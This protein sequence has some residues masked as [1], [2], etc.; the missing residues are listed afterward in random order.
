[1]SKQ[2]NK[3][4]SGKGRKGFRLPLDDKSGK[5]N[6]KD[7]AILMV[8]DTVLGVLGGMAGSAADKFSLVA[9]A[10]VSLAGHYLDSRA[11]QSFG[12]GMIVSNG[13]TRNASGEK[14]YENQS[15]QGFSPVKELGNVKARVVN[16][17]DNISEK[18]PFHYMK[19]KAKPATEESG[20]E[21][22]GFG[23][24]EA[25]WNALDE[26]ENKIIEAAKEFQ[27]MGNNASLPAH[28]NE[29]EI[30]GM[31]ENEVEFEEV[32]DNA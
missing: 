25:N 10:G 31:N 29:N 32:P 15:L 1:M 21:V 14:T 6:L 3:N 19:K 27:K 2:K 30:S 7:S 5:R 20:E 22:R 23:S 24:I 28:D 26:E 13:Y 16:F 17:T 8:R 12:I 4:E 11:V 9:G 18:W